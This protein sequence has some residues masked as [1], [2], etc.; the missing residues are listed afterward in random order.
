MISVVIDGLQFFHTTR[1]AV[2][3]SMDTVANV[4]SM[5]ISD[6]WAQGNLQRQIKPYDPCQ[7]FIGA[8]K[9]IDGY[10]DKVTP[11]ITPTENTITLSARDKTGDLVD[12]AAVHSVGQWNGLTL[13]KIIKD[14]CQPFGINVTVATDVGAPIPYFRLDQ[15]MTAFEAI[16]KL[17]SL[18]SIL[19]LADDKGGIILT[20]A[21]DD[22][23]NYQL[24]QGFNIIEGTATYDGSERFSEYI[25]KGQALTS[26]GLTG[27]ISFSGVGK[28]TDLNV[29]RYR[30]TVIVESAPV[31]NGT[32]Q[33]IAKWE[34]AKRRG[35]S[36]NFKIKIKG[37][38][39]DDGS[40][41]PINKQ[42]F[43]SSNYLGVNANML[44]AAIDYSSD[45]SGD[46]TTFTLTPKEA[47]TIIPDL[48]LEKPKNQNSLLGSQFLD[49]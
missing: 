46:F 11:R 10:I 25:I 3:V 12:C 45:N 26:E 15:S 23:I 29:P 43:L 20:L 34:L 48:T 35:K 14:I 8:N 17:C 13:D 44:I 5:E 30:P 1:S 27:E 38:L 19:P 33:Q 7:V 9:I 28:V 49:A 18:R 37:L 42:V 39:Q 2:T 41:W 36:Q 47:Y 21:S 40:L 32:C 31:N 4:L 6:R 24:I 22:V 16:N